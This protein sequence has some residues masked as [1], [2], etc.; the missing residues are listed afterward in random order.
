MLNKIFFIITFILFFLLLITGMEQDYNYRENIQTDANYI[1]RYIENINVEDY[2]CVGKSNQYYQ[3]IPKRALVVGENI[4]ETFIAL[5]IEDNILLAAGYGN[6]YFLPNEKYAAKYYNLKIENQINLGF[7]RTLALHPDLIVGG[8]VIF[9][10]RKLKSTKFWNDRSIHTFCSLN[11]NSPTNKNFQETLENEFKFIIDL[12]K[13]Y[14][15]ENQAMELVEAMKKDIYFI[16]SKTK[17]LKKPKV[18]IIEDMGGIVVYGKN[19]LAGDICTK[20]NGDVQSSIQ[21]MIGIEDLIKTDPDVLFVVKSGGDPEDAAEVF[22]KMRALQ[23]IK[24]V[25]NNR[26]YGIA[27]NYTYNSAIKTGEG[28]RKF[29]AGMYPQIAHELEGYNL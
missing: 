16:N 9:S 28:I 5:G 7:E 4:I 14:D 21:P 8:Q 24:C 15:K 12:G 10:N 27:L 19:K 6:P 2:H 29:A 25:K 17:N 20:L 11:A 23:N 3:K 1:P 22:R 18:M 13:I 26:V